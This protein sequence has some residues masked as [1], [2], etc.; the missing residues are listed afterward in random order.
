VAQDGGLRQLWRT[1]LKTAQWT[2]IE[3]GGTAGGV[4]DSE[5]CFPTGRQGWIENKRTLG[6]AV[7]FRP[8]QVGWLLRRA[9]M[10][11]TCFVAVR[12]LN[13]AE[14]EL[15]LVA[16]RYADALQDGGLR[17]VTH[18]RWGGGP[19]RWNWEEVEWHLRGGSIRAAGALGRIGS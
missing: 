18:L 16:G 13:G 9:R 15:Y 19:A 5:Y 8:M 17:A 10:G 1:H 2:P 11:G 12:R 6:W 14:D 3:T 7:K 4:P